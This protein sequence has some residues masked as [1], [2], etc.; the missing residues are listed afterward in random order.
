TGGAGLKGYNL[1]RNGVFVRQVLA[2]TTSTADTGL[3]ASTTY[4]YAV[5]A[6]DNAGNESARSGTVNGTTPACA[7]TTPPSGP[8]GVTPAVA[9]CNQINVFWSASTDGGGSGLKGY[10]FYRNGVFVK[11]VLAP[12]TAT[13]DVG[14]AA[15][16][17]YSYAVSAVDNAGNQS[18]KSTTV[19]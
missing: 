8:T 2:P 4:A 17:T 1:Y 13:A 9:S 14:L 11:Q 19:N 16:S 3:G 10:N 6:I 15:S 5:S 18:A 7:G 12:A